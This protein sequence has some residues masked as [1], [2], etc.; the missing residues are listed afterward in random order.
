ML[1]HFRKELSAKILTTLLR[2]LSCTDPNVYIFLLKLTLMVELWAFLSSL[3]A[4]IACFTTSYEGRH[5]VMIT[6]MHWVYTAKD[7]GLEFVQVLME[8]PYWN[9]S[10][11][12]ICYSCRWHNQYSLSWIWLCRINLLLI[13]IWHLTSD[14]WPQV[15][16]FVRSF[17]THQLLSMRAHTQFLWESYF[18]SVEKIVSTTLEVRLRVNTTLTLSRTFPELLELATFGALGNFLKG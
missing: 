11:A 4:A 3:S 6:T 7:W 16:H 15:P 5:T 17:S 10:F 13:D 8:L 2:L 12:K 18:S 1:D 14:L 9:L